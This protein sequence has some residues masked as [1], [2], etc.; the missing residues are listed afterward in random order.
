MTAEA[1]VIY[2]S[3]AFPA[4]RSPCTIRDVML[5]LWERGWAVICPSL[6]QD[7]MMGDHSDIR[8]LTALQWA[9]ARNETL[10]ARSDALFLMPGW[11]FCDEGHALYD[12]AERY[13]VGVFCASAESPFP[14]SPVAVP[15]ERRGECCE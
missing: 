1:S 11:G 6:V 3:P 12:L 10:L 13:G 15:A 2:L 9:R 14:F 4:G 5:G 8:M 7:C